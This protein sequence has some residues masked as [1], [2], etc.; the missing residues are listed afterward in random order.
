[1]A[2]QRPPPYRLPNLVVHFPKDLLGDGVLVEVRPA[3]Q[4]RIQGCNQV[5]LSRRAGCLYESSGSAQESDDALSGGFRQN[6]AVPVLAYIVS[7]EV[8]ALSDMRNASLLLR[9]FQASGAEEIRDQ[10][11]DLGLQQL[12]RAPGDDEVSRPGA[13]LENG[14]S[15][16]LSQ[17]SE[18]E[19]R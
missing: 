17:R 1:M 11:S 7:E 9:E 14:S 13:A 16:G 18:Q 2:S 10:R 12:F 3:S 15:D 4:Q 5:R 19:S 6:L 8:E